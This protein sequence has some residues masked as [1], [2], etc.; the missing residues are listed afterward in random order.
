MTGLQLRTDGSIWTFEFDTSDCAE[1]IHD[2]IDG[3]L[4][5]VRQN[6]NSRVTMYANEDGKRLNLPINFLATIL[7]GLWPQDYVVGNVVLVGAPDDEGDDQGLPTE[8]IEAVQAID[9]KESWK[10][11]TQGERHTPT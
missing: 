2:L 1:K 6:F 10:K 5:P 4:E 9:I 11:L 8:V 7:S 3:W